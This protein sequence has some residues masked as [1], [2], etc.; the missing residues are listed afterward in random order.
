M[1]RP[2]WQSETNYPD[3]FAE[4]FGDSTITA[5]RIAWAIATY[6]RTLYPGETP[7]DRFM[8]GQSD[9][10]TA[11]QI[12]GWEFF[13]STECA[14]CH[15]P[16]LFTDN[17]YRNIGLR[18]VVEDGGRQDVTGLFEDRGKFKVP[19]LRNTGLKKKYMHNGHFTR[20]QDVLAFYIG[21]YAPFFTDNQDPLIPPIDIPLPTLGPLVDF[22]E[23][24]LTDPRVV[25]E[26]FPFDYPTLRGERRADF[27]VFADCLSGPGGQP[28]PTPPRP[29]AE[30]SDLFDADGDGDVDITDY[31]TLLWNFPRR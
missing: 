28:N 4:A 13:Q 31:Q 21:S 15:V 19:M 10:M 1:F 8:A 11:S 9:A 24:G 2:N 26:A 7:W 14:E 30:C 17:T 20:L 27:P 22:L 18:D 25:A 3:L 5:E 12:E 16:P 6:E 23:N 29:A